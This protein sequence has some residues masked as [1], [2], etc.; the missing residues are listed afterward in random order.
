IPDKM[1]KEKSII[2]VKFQASAG[3]VGGIYGVRLLRNKPKPETTKIIVGRDAAVVN[4]VPQFRARAS[5]ESLELETGAPLQG[6]VTLKIYSM[7]GRL[8]KAKMLS[9]GHT[10]F[11]IGIADMNNGVYIMRL[12]R[13]GSLVGSSI[14]SKRGKI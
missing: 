2:R 4:S 14:F 13:E 12:M 5:Q 6:N 8:V 11:S 1:V 7:D 9:A 10:T 3:M